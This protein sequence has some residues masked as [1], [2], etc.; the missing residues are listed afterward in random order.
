MKTL[1][2]RAFV[3]LSVAGAAGFATGMAHA[4]PASRPGSLQVFKSP[5]C[6]CCGSW[7]E[8]MRGAGFEVDVTEIEDLDPVKLRYGVAGDLQ[9]CHTAIIDGYVIEGHVPAREVSRIL[10]ERPSAIGLAVPGMPSGSPGMEQ[11]GQ[12]DPYQVVLFTETE[13]KVFAQY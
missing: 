7:V 5:W 1:S 9:S 8:H 12:K 13:R 10:A 6:G 11:G 2:R 3:A 4:A